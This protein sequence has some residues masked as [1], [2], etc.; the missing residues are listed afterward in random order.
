MGCLPPGHT[1]WMQISLIWLKK[2]VWWGQGHIARLLQDAKLAS[3]GG[4][5]PLPT[6]VEAVLPLLTLGSLYPSTSGLLLLLF[7]RGWRKPLLL[8]N[9]PEFVSAELIFYVRFSGLTEVVMVAG[10]QGRAVTQ[11]TG[12]LKSSHTILST[13]PAVPLTGSVQSG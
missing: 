5:S 1:H 6:S 8:V 12:E 2:L 4:S 11:N 9:L 13:L 3:P 7:L 10:N